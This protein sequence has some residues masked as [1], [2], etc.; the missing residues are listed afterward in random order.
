MQPVTSIPTLPED[1]VN[2]HEAL[3]ALMPPRSDYFKPAGDFPTRDDLVK[4]AR[5]VGM[6]GENYGAST[7]KAVKFFQAQEGLEPRRA[8]SMDKATADKMNQY[9]QDLGA[10]DDPDKRVVFGQVRYAPAGGTT[11]A[12]AHDTPVYVFDESGSRTV[13]LN[14]GSTNSDGR[15]ELSFMFSDGQKRW[16]GVPVAGGGFDPKV[17]LTRDRDHRIEKNLVVPQGVVTQDFTVQGAVRRAQGEPDAGM[18]IPNVTVSAFVASESNR[19]LTPSGTTVASGQYMIR[20]TAKAGATLFVAIESSTGFAVRSSSWTNTGG[21]TTKD[22]EL[23]SLANDGAYIV[24]GRVTGALPASGVLVR[25]FDKDIRSEELLGE[26]SPG[27]DGQYEIRYGRS[28]FARGEKPGSGAELRMRVMSGNQQLPANSTSSAGPYNAPQITVINLEVLD[29]VSMSLSEFERHLADIEPVRDTVLVANFTDADIEFVAGETGI[30]RS[31]VKWLSLA[32][33]D[34]VSMRAAGKDIPAAAFYG[35]FREGLP[36]DLEALSAEPI[37]RLRFALNA[38]LDEALVPS[39]L[40]ALVDKLLL[41]VPNPGRDE[42]VSIATGLGWS[43]DTI[44]ALGGTAGSVGKVG[45]SLVARLVGSGTLSADQGHAIGLSVSLHGLLDGQSAAL[46]GIRAFQFDT[47][48]G[49]QLTRAS[50]LAIPSAKDWAKALR[51]AGATSPDGASPEEYA[52]QLARNVAHAFPTDALLHRAV[53]TRDISQAWT[54]ATMQALRVKNRRLLDTAW[55]ALDLSDIAVPKRDQLRTDFDLLVGF[56]NLHPGLELRALYYAQADAAAGARDVAA[57]V[58]LFESVHRLNQPAAAGATGV[59]LL[60]VDYLPGSTSLPAVQFGETP[61]GE[62][63]LIVS[64][65]K[66]Y[67]RV[68][69]VTANAPASLALLAAGYHSATRLSQVSS[70]RLAAET[71]IALGEATLYKERADRQTQRAALRWFSIHDTERDRVLLGPRYFT[72][73]PQAYLA[74]LP[75]YAEMFGN[76]A[77]CECD[78]CFSVLSPAA[79]FVDLMHY[80]EQ[81]ILDRPYALAADGANYPGGLPESHSLHLKARRPDLWTLPLT[82]ANTNDMLPTLDIVNDVLGRFISDAY[83]LAGSRQPFAMLALQAQSPRQPASWPLEQVSGYLAHFEC[84]RLQIARALLLPQEALTR[85]RLGLSLRAASQL[86]VGRLGDVDAAA[87]LYGAWLAM[88]KLPVVVTAEI[89]DVAPAL[90]VRATGLEH[91]RL[92]AIV[93]SRFANADDPAHPVEIKTGIGAAGGVQNDT[94]FIEHLSIRRLDRIERFIRLANRLPWSTG[95]LDQV[96]SSLLAGAA[97]PAQAELDAIAGLLDMQ[98]RWHL[99]ID[100]LCALWSDLPKLALRDGDTA[101]WDRRFNLPQFVRADGMWPPAPATAGIFLPA[102]MSPDGKSQPADSSQQRLLAALQVTDADLVK[103]FVALRPA[104]EPAPS[105]VM[106]PAPQ[107]IALSGPNLVLLYRHARLARMLNVGVDGL[108]QAIALVQRDIAGAPPTLQRI[109]SLRDLLALIEAHNELVGTGFSLEQ[110]AFIRDPAAGP[111]DA[112][113]AA[114]AIQSAVQTEA[115]LTFADAVF[116]QLGLGETQSRKLVEANTGR[117]AGDGL[118]LEVNPG[119]STYR[120][121]ADFDPAIEASKFDTAA[122]KESVLRAS[123]TAAILSIAAQGRFVAADLASTGLALAP[124]NQCVAVAD[125]NAAA[126][127]PF[128]SMSVGG[129]TAYRLRSGATAAL[130]LPNGIDVGEVFARRAKALL[131]LYHWRTVL[132]ARLAVAMKLAADRCAAL[133]FLAMQIKPALETDLAAALQGGAATPI[134]SLMGWVA[135]LALLFRNQVYDAQTLRFITTHRKVF[136][137]DASGTIDTPA[138]VAS[139]TYAQL[140][141]LPDKAFSATSSSTDPS[142]DAAP[143]PVIVALRALVSGNAADSQNL[144][145]ALRADAS[146][147]DAL[148]K[149]MPADV[150]AALAGIRG[151]AAVRAALALANRLGINPELLKLAVWQKPSTATDADV[152]AE[153]A[154]LQRAADGVLALF[155]ASYAKD[156]Q[157]QSMFEPYQD[158]LH[159]RQRDI[160]LEFMTHNYAKADWLQ[161][162]ASADSLYDYFLI[163]VQTAGCSRTSRLV[164]ATSSVQLYVHRCVMRLERTD[165]PDGETLVIGFARTRDGLLRAAEWIWRKNYRVWE[166]N[167]KVFLYPETYIEP[168]LRDDKTPLFKELEDTLLQQEISEQ[169]VLDAYANYLAG[170]DEIARLKIAGAYHDHDRKNSP[171][172]L[173]LFGVTSSDPP[174]YY[175]R[176]IT[177]LDDVAS[178]R[179]GHWTKLNISI[180]ARKVAP[181]VTNGR[182]CVFWIEVTTRP[183]QDFKDGNST[184]HGYRHT[185]HTKYSQLRLDGRW[186]VPETLRSDSGDGPVDTITVPDVFQLNI[187]QAGWLAGIGIGYSDTPPWDGRKRHHIGPIETYKP[188]DWR[189]DRIYPNVATGAGA[190][191]F[192][193]GPRYPVPEEKTD[194]SLHSVPVPSI[195]ETIDFSARLASSNPKNPIWTN[196]ATSLCR[197]NFPQQD[198]AIDSVVIAEVTKA[199]EPIALPYFYASHN[200]QRAIDVHGTTAS[201][202]AELVRTPTLSD[203]QI[204]AGNELA[205]FIEPKND[206][207]LLK[208]NVNASTYTLRRLGTTLAPKLQEMLTRGGIP[209]LLSLDGQLDLTENASAAT[210]A[211]PRVTSL[212]ARDGSPFADSS[213]LLTYYREIYFHIPFLIADHLNSRQMFGDA[214]RWYRYVFDPTAPARTPDDGL[215]RPWRYREFRDKKIMALDTSLTETGA[216]EAYRNDPF[217][218]YAIARLRPGTFQKAVV[219]KYIDNL[220]DWGD[221]LFTQFTMESVNEA[222]MLY[223]MAADILGP[224]PEALGPCGEKASDGDTTYASLRADLNDISDILIEESEGLDMRFPVIPVT[225][226]IFGSFVPYFY[227]TVAVQAPAAGGVQVE[228]VAATRAALGVGDEVAFGGPGNLGAPDPVGWNRAAP[229]TAV[230]TGGTALSNFGN[231]VGGRPVVATGDPIG[232]TTPAIGGFSG[233][234][235]PLT[236]IKFGTHVGILDIPYDLADV[237]PFPGFQFPPRSREAPPQLDLFHLAKAAIVFCLPDNKDL[238]A[239]WDRVESSLFKIRNCMDISGARRQLQLFA[240]EIDPHMLVRM[241]TA[242]LSLDDVL[243]V[244]RGNLP[245][246]RFLFLIDKAKQHASTVQSFGSQLLSALEKCDSEELTRLRTVHEQNLLQ[247]RSTMMQWEID[248]AEDAIATLTQQQATAAY[249][250][251]YYDGLIQQGLVPWERTH[252]IATHAA[253]GMLATQMTLS[254]VGGGVALAPNV[255]APTAMTYGGVQLGNS[256]HGF[257]TA[258][259]VVADVSELV[260]KSA[261]IEATFQRRDN[262]WRNQLELARREVAQF[263]KQIAAAGI[264]RDIATQSRQV[265]LRSIEQTQEVFDFMRDRFTNF[266]RYTWLA[267]RLQGLNRMAFDSAIST[268]TL[269]E[270]AYRFERPDEGNDPL[271]TGG[272]WDASNAGLLAG[273]RLQLDLQILERR[274]LETNDRLLEVEQAFSVQQIDPSALIKLRQTG[275]CTF[276]V[277]ELFMDLTY[278]GHYRR[279]V[280]AVR[281]SI[282]CVVGPYANVGATLNLVG[283]E[284]RK[285]AIDSQTTIVPP[286]HVTSVATSSAQNDAGV[287]EFSFRDERYMPFEGAGVISEWELRLPS[288]VPSFD[289]KTI[290]DVILRIAYT[291]SAEDA[292]RSKVENTTSA[293]AQSL[294]ALLDAPGLVRVFSLRHEF[295]T[296]WSRLVNGPLGTEVDLAI[297]AQDLPYFLSPMTFKVAS[298]DLL[299]SFNGSRQ[300]LANYPEFWI[301]AEST[302]DANNNSIFKTDLKTGLPVATTTKA[303]AVKGIHKL[304]LITAGDLAPAASAAQPAPALDTKVLSDILLRVALK[305]TS[306]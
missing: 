178:T 146:R 253:V 198:P 172:T 181:V 299:L 109:A 45:D 226:T 184:F 98:A 284:I 240:P 103:L 128:E 277:P 94:E 29:Q 48:P 235:D 249:R 196:S 161:R 31:H 122:I 291:A 73:E 51:A 153:F 99:P 264:R 182:L 30:D 225:W 217:N 13:I 180:T 241:K 18:P 155:H 159:S 275:Y 75:G 77:R 237:R 276:K 57:R 10:F 195:P 239:Y 208:P 44:A 124:V 255:G 66:A 260:G 68:Q 113:G 256:L 86:L 87:T 251:D 158:Q 157:F 136:G 74:Q 142:A 224:A 6:E 60:H 266:G 179:Y 16:V 20:A 173:H 176:T 62:K 234:F 105:A 111:A 298:L 244:T 143:S 285:N 246:Y 170:F 81:Q 114:V 72:A 257:A 262:E 43:S 305:R 79:Y 53:D 3:Q 4:L 190:V 267:E 123:L 221:S 223:V 210:I 97:T 229:R 206:S 8:G 200:I 55:H 88:G 96:L 108:F 300:S 1:I 132:Q 192:A 189:W 121:R 174:V 296:E 125:A 202:S 282:P 243:N 290:S 115:T 15:Y 148:L 177:D 261:S 89:A 101:L 134:V 167:R 67:Q 39:S 166:A 230:G 102:A 118:A 203:V 106:A 187:L 91:A 78:P 24:R 110:L 232:P 47:V 233:V 175:Y 100:E 61:D 263:D 32:A 34:E 52:N 65:L 117:A 162:F 270:E 220:L 28:D 145:L 215:L 188:D 19:K 272:Y 116:T 292:L 17:Q 293:A 171:D 289:Y 26:C 37:E 294:L 245:P 70:V 40:R 168:G 9:L 46:P 58:A 214:Q 183:L 288:V 281:L 127:G 144:G 268:A 7:S 141:T 280:R 137:L 156:G 41:A 93:T 133:Y 112:Q 169:N 95:E 119:A 297:T 50:D 23:S 138:L 126:G 151:V 304:K 14:K 231:S 154:D 201:F 152:A 279:R 25:A 228:G 193:F 254:I 204:L 147:I 2:L 219:M 42:L 59:D 213:A 248:A 207:L 265:H 199:Q 164:A 36:D 33:Q 295:P 303:Y 271:L 222:T 107:P 236:G 140:S 302:T 11:G 64:N 150:V 258:A 139:A 238:R 273:D 92:L 76:I 63:P 250:R 191:V 56:T 278:P 71:G 129:Q 287:F 130:L 131:T 135:R 90:L 274:F 38:A 269:A 5:Y 194:A 85:A 286:R 205:S 306:A 259:K 216:L 242:G 80:V 120:L 21:T 104:L 22:L 186:G 54:N 218:P 247:M 83:G 185:V 197:W 212:M 283:S 49:R 27:S 163:D 12:P 35:W 82:C 211:D 227:S 149:A 165:R 69:A 301:E 252:Q 209:G 160:L 84:D